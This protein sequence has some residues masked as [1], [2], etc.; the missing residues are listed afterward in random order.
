VVRYLPRIEPQHEQNFYQIGVIVRTVQGS[1]LAHSSFSNSVNIIK[2]EQNCADTNSCTLRSSNVINQ[3]PGSTTRSPST[4]A[5]ILGLGELAQKDLVGVLLDE[6]S[7]RP[8]DVKVPLTI[9]F[10]G[11]G[12]PSNLVATIHAGRQAFYI[13]PFQP[14]INPGTYTVKAHFAGAEIPGGTLSPSDSQVMS[15]TIQPSP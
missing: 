13:A 3:E 6:G 11:T 2:S 14:P 1:T 12:V 15:F 7:E 9:S 10:T 5:T 4:F 8:V